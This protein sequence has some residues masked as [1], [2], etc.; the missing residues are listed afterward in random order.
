[1]VIFQDRMSAAIAGSVVT[2]T[3]DATMPTQPSDLA[4]A[5]VVVT[6]V[7][8]PA[9]TS[10]WEVSATRKQFYRVTIERVS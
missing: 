6:A 8:N 3:P 4:L 2:L 5:S 7:A 10:F 1:M 9:P